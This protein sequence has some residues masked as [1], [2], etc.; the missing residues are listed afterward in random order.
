MSLSEK[1]SN[2]FNGVPE[3]EYYEEV[4]DSK[5]AVSTNTDVNRASEPEKDNNR[6]VMSLMSSKNNSTTVQREQK[7]MVFDPSVFSD[8]KNIGKM[9]LNGR[10]VIV[11]FRK[12]D[13]NQIH[14]VIDFLS[15]LIFAVNGDMQRIGEKIFLCTPKNFKIEGD[16]SNLTG[17]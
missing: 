17:R 10:A 9:I 12:M 13:E 11:N 15:G 8:V 7:I 2:W 14:R 3:E 1:L 5:Q 16:L 6:Q 4:T